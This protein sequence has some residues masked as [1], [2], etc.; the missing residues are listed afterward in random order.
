MFDCPGCLVQSLRAIVSNSSSSPATHKPR[1][2]SALRPRRQPLSPRNHYFFSQPVR[3]NTRGV[4]Y[5]R[6]SEK[7]PAVRREQPFVLRPPQIVA[8]QKSKSEDVDRSKTK[9]GL[10]SR[11]NRELI[12]KGDPLVFGDAIRALLR[13]GKQD[14]ALAAVRKASSAMDCTVSWNYVISFEMQQKR[15]QKAWQAYQEM[16][17][18]GQKPDG[19]TITALLKGL[20]E[21]TNVPSALSR[22][23]S[24][25]HSLS[26]PNSPL[27]GPSLIHLNAV[28]NVC[29]R[30]KDL[31]AMWGVINNLPTD[32]G[33]SM[34]DHITYSV[35]LGTLYDVAK[36]ERDGVTTHNKVD[37][38]SRY[39]KAV[40]D[41]RTV[42]DL[43]VTQW[44]D[45]E[46]KL[47]HGLI[48]AMGRLLLLGSREED[49][50]D[51]FALITQTTRIDSQKVPFFRR[52]TP[53]KDQKPQEIDANSELIV[54]KT[55]K[56][57]SDDKDHTKVRVS[58]RMSTERS[59]RPFPDSEF[60]AVSPRDE[61][62]LS[63]YRG[64]ASPSPQT[65]AILLEACFALQDSRAAQKYWELFTTEG[66]VQPDVANTATFLRILR[67]S[68]SSAVASEL[69]QWFPA[70]S[71]YSSEKEI[72][73]LG[74]NTEKKPTSTQL[75]PT[76]WADN[77]WPEPKLFIIAMA[78]CRRDSRNWQV[79]DH[80]LAILKSQ[81]DYRRQH[82]PVFIKMYFETIQ[83]A[84]EM[85]PSEEGRASKENPV[86]TS[87]HLLKNRITVAERFEHAIPAAD[88]LTA[89]LVRIRAASKPTKEGQERETRILAMVE[90]YRSVAGALLRGWYPGNHQVQRD[91]WS[92]RLK[93]CQELLSKKDG[94]QPVSVKR[95]EDGAR[96]MRRSKTRE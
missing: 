57:E 28:L 5:A 24:I 72:K 21:N 81:M 63:N 22:A 77:F 79:A 68:R 61:S 14:E 35:V 65:L 13:K 58:G 41:G 83:R 34:S 48:A 1:L 18:R 16:K 19:H 62:K 38:Q 59:F 15:L 69:I 8:P 45:G 70:E 67:M 3:T 53:S 71:S 29:R 56:T 85:T 87:N 95:S 7:S 32:S 11:R 40:F 73:D 80:A 17:K 74:S 47:D 6:P 76:N 88:S 2:Y 44:K 20:S 86:S 89:E 96:R 27:K 43:V 10:V 26:A 60:R 93:S 51:V 84:W 55:E 4:A 31:D 46:I 25:Y 82:D 94:E 90:E 9:V 42:W 64:F 33:K 52:M 50:L 49:I 75:R 91:L 54:S 23:L 92:K 78:T 12:D 66:G 39:D 30:A 37:T 36:D